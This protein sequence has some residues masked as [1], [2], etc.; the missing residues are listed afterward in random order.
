MAKESTKSETIVRPVETAFN[1][2]SVQQCV[3][4]DGKL[5]SIRKLYSTEHDEQYRENIARDLSGVTVADVIAEWEAAN[6]GATFDDTMSIEDFI[7][8]MAHEA[9]DA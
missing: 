9:A 1:R 5:K 8:S 3:L 7:H 6:D 2:A 4:V